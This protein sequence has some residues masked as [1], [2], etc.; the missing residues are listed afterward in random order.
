MNKKSAYVMNWRNRTKIKLIEY[1]GGKC[2]ICKYDK[3]IPSVYDFHH[4]NPDEKDFAISGKALAFETL[5]KEVDKCQLLCANC[6]NELHWN[7]DQEK[8]AA[9][10]MF[11]KTNPPLF[12]KGQKMECA[13][14]KKEFIRRWHRQKY[15][16][17]QCTTMG[18]RKIKDRPSKEELAELIKDNSYVTLGKKFGVRD[19]S[20]KKWVQ[21]YGLQRKG[22]CGNRTH[23][24]LFNKQMLSPDQANGPNS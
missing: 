10:E 13:W 20:I 5:K 2:E 22:P 1:K 19:N 18:Q 16:S 6:H 4:K 11:Q 9:R 12:K 17:K 14:C 24:L 23:H 21:Q 15:C 7:L 8:R 3:L